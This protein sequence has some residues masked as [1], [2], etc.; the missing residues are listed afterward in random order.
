MKLPG[1]VAAAVLLAV[2]T[3]ALAAPGLVTTSV[4][5]R[6]GPGPG[7]P[8]V[9]RI[10]GG[11]H[12]N[13]HGCIR[14]A[15]WCDVSWSDDRGWVAAEYLEYYYRNRYVLLSD[16]VDVIDVPIVPFALSTY[17]A[18]YYSGRPWYHRL[19]YWNSYW[20]SHARFATQL[21]T[22]RTTRGVET[23][24]RAAIAREPIG[25]R[26]VA[27]VR[28]ARA[29]RFARDNRTRG[30]AQGIPATRQPIAGAR[31]AARV[32]G[33]RFSAAPTA[34]RFAQPNVGRPGAI[35]RP[36]GAP[37]AARVQPSQPLAAHAQMGGPRPMGGGAA[38]H[39]NAAP[40]PRAG[41]VGPAG[42]APGR[43][44]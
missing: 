32:E 44:H 15:S 33:N 31:A 43:H 12:V 11:A 2:P 6:A 22:G 20:Q 30:F 25:R 5:M 27:E 42:G 37:I 24:D 35:G 40:A 21:P 3:A 16:Y 28:G 7:F 18:S 26:G 13:I 29:D 9:D 34:G 8:A 14:G 36:G 39:I 10:P 4:S 19:A 23:R 41:G 17:W 1:F 38:P